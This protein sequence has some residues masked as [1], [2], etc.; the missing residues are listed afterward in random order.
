[1][2]ATP[3]VLLVGSTL[4]ASFVPLLADGTVNTTSTLTT[5]PTWS[6]DNT[7]VATVDANGLITGVGAGSA[8]ITGSQGSFTDSDGQVAGPFDASNTVS[9]T[10]PVQRTVSA[11]VN[12]A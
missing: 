8:T 10:A 1:M 2:P 3:G 9:D 7:S 5:P 4:Q 11:Q 12:F 6:S